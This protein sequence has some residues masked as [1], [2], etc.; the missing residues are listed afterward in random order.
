ME[1]LKIL[2]EIAVALAL[3]LGGFVFSLWK[4]DAKRAEQRLQE[5]KV[6]H[7]RQLETTRLAAEEREKER[8]HELQ[9]AQAAAEREHQVEVKTLQETVIHLQQVV[10]ERL[11][12]ALDDARAAKTTLTAA[13]QEHIAAI[14]R[15]N[16]AE[17]HAIQALQGD[18]TSLKEQLPQQYQDILV[19]IASV[20]DQTRVINDALGGLISTVAQYHESVECALRAEETNH[21]DPVGESV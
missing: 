10:E 11:F 4:W 5:A 17:L 14:D 13:V 21:V 8:A 7:T 3:P 15:A 1:E 16:Q 18:V 12:S 20:I 9:L 19:R 6:D 2:A